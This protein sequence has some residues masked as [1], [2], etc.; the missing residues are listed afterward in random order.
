MYIGLPP[1]GPFLPCK[2]VPADATAYLFRKRVDGIDK[3]RPPFHLRLD[4]CVSFPVNDGLMTVRHVI[5]RQLPAV[6]HFRFCDR[7]RHV[8]FLPPDVPGI[9]LVEDELPHRAFLEVI[10][11]RGAD[12]RPVHAPRNLPQ[13]KP[14]NVHL[15]HPP[16]SLRLLRYDDV[17]LHLFIIPVSE[18]VLVR[19]PDL[20]RL[21]PLP[22][23]PLHVFRNAPAL[24]L[25][26][27]SQE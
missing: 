5:L 9:Y 8:A 27:G 26:K 12:A 11:K 2:A 3:P 15:E 13:G 19:R 20:A 22:D 24:L 16:D 21:E 10:A 1:Y 23:S 6:F 4:L 18:D 7:V 14:V 25:R 17:L